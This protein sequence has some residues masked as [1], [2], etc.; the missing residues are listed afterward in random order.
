M[1][2]K[3][4]IKLTQRRAVFALLCVILT[5]QVESQAVLNLVNNWSFE[6]TLRC[7]NNAGQ[8][9]YSK[10]WFNPVLAGNPDYFNSCANSNTLISSSSTR[11][12]VPQNDAGFQFPRTG[13]SFSGFA[14]YVKSISSYREYIKNKLKTNTINT[15]SYCVTF[16]VSRSDSSTFAS[17]NIGAYFSNDSI[18]STSISPPYILNISPNIEELII[19]KDTLNWIKIEN[20]YVANGNEYFLT[21]GNFRN[22]GGTAFIQTKPLTMSPIQLN[23]SYYYIDDVSVV[24][25]N[26]ANAATKDTLFSRC[27]SDSVILGTD[28]TEFATYTWQ[29]TAA[30]LAALSCTNCPNPIAKPLTTT[31]Y[32]LSKVQCSATTMDSVTV[33]VLTPS[34]QANA[35]QDKNICPNEIVSLGTQDSTAFVNYNWQF[36]G[37]SSLSCT[38]CA[39]PLANIQQTTEFILQRSE[40][41]ITTSDTVKVN[42]DFCDI[43]IPNVFT[44]NAD[45]VNDVWKFKLPAG[46]K[47]GE[48]NIF[49]RWGLLV[50][51]INAEQFPASP[52]TTNNESKNF[53]MQWDGYT[54]SGIS[55]SDGVYFYTLTYTDKKSEVINMKG[56]VSLFR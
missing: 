37:G 9:Y 38:N 30:G 29:S 19:L 7:P 24:E 15:K 2:S 25:I 28:S 47:P 26:S 33:V 48:L 41:G 27:V 23:Y 4:N 8:V 22:D 13:N 18:I 49:N 1:P 32:Y 43:I 46:A 39:T 6:D 51:S 40:C 55:C 17:A 35:G 10:H 21:I 14:T 56:Y 20:I 16:Y 5:L 31:K 53:I 50:Y 52:I 44:P 3:L 12:A 54:T 36:I 42:I 11:I 34:T 45:N